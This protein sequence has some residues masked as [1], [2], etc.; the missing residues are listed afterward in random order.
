MTYS[1]AAGN[2]DPP[3][4]PKTGSSKSR[5][6]L[7]YSKTAASDEMSSPKKLTSP[8]VSTG[9]TP[10]KCA[11]ASDILTLCRRRRVVKQKVPRG[12]KNCVGTSGVLMGNTG[13]KRQARASD[14]ANS[15]W[16]WL[17]LN[18]SAVIMLRVSPGGDFALGRSSFLALGRTGQYGP[19]GPE[20]RRSDKL[21]HRVHVS[22]DLLS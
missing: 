21:Q 6:E 9:M 22:R 1:T 20:G 14:G 4:K 19:G 7:S 13:P 8:R 10:S 12:G 15:G 2:R 18:R 16:Q 11:D 17:Q 3:G 5:P